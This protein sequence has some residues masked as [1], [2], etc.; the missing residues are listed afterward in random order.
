VCAKLLRYVPFLLA[1]ALNA[2]GGSTSGGG[3]L[4][5]EETP[6]SQVTETPDNTCSTCHGRDGSSAPPL[7]LRGQDDPA[8]RGVGAHDA[9]LWQ[10][11]LGADISCESCHLVPGAIDD[12]GHTDTTWP[13]EVIFSGLASSHEL[14]P[15]THVDDPS[16]QAASLTCTSVYCHGATL[17]GGVFTEPRWNPPDER[18]SQCNACHG[19]PPPAPHPAQP[20]CS[21]C[22]DAVAAPD[23]TIL[24][25][26][27]H[28]N[29]TVD[30]ALPEACDACHGSADTPAPPPD[31]TG[32]TNPDHPGV[33][34][35]LAHLFAEHKLSKPVE[36]TECHVVPASVN[37]PGHL[38]D[39]SPG[40]ELTFGALA[41]TGTAEPSYDPSAGK[42][43]SVYCHGA[44]LAGGAVTAPVWTDTSVQSAACGAC[45]AV[46]PP[47]PHVHNLECGLCHSATAEGMA[48]AHPENHINGVVDLDANQACN[49]CHGSDVNAAP[50]LDTTGGSTTVLTSVGAHQPHLLASSGLT[51]PVACDACHVVP[52]AMNVNGHIDAPPAEV[53]FGGLAVANGA[54]PAWNHVDATCS[55]VYCHGATLAGGART[56]PLWTKVDGTQDTCGSCHGV[57]P[58]APHAQS[59]DCGMCHTQ[60]AKG[61]S[62]AHPEKHIDGTLQVATDQSCHACHG[63]ELNDAPPVDS[64]GNSATALKTIGAHQSHLQALSNI[65]APIAC[66][67]CHVVPQTVNDATHVDAPPAEVT[68]GALATTGDLLPE[69]NAADGTCS[70]TYCHGATLLGG[71]HTSPLWTK[72][73]GTQDACGSCHGVPPP[74]PHVQNLHCGLCHFETASDMTIA[75]P[76]KHVDGVLQVAEQQ[77][78]HSCHGSTTNDAPPVDTVGA[79]DTA[80]VSIGAHQEHLQATS[81]LSLPVECEQCHVRPTEVHQPGHIDFAPAE[82]TFGALASADGSSPQWN[83]V[84]ATC[85]SVYCHGATLEGGVRTEPVWTQVDHTQDACGSCHGLPPPL[86]HVQRNDCGMCHSE[87]ASGMAIVH[88]EKH[89]DGQVQVDL[90]Q[91]CNA[92]HGSEV[93]AAPP[94]DLAGASA[95]TLRTVGAHQPHLQ[96]TS[97]LS[98]PVACTECHVV[99]AAVTDAGHLGAAPA[100]IT[101]GTLAKAH[102]ANP[103][104]SAPDATCSSV[105]CHGAT[106]TGGSDTVP[107]WTRVDN[108]EDA[109]GACHGIPPPAPHVQNLNCGLCHKATAVGSAIVHPEKHINGTLDVE[110]ALSCHSCHGSDA[111]DAPPLDTTGGTSTNLT[112]VGAHQAHVKAL[113]GLSTP[114]DCTACHVKPAAVGDAGHIDAPPAE[115]TFNELAK[116]AG[117]TPT[118]DRASAT[119]S[120]TYCHG[121]TLSGGTIT[122]PAWTTVD[123]TEDACGTCHGAPPPLPHLQSDDCGACH[124]ETAAGNT[125]A[126]PEKHI[127]GVLQVIGSE[128][129]N[130]CHGNADNPAPP[131]DT[132]GGSD[133]T[134]VTVGAHQAH[135]QAEDGIAP[136]VAC[137]E[138]HVKP[139]VVSD[140][141]H[142][143]GAPAEVTFGDTASAGGATPTWNRDDATC[144]STY[145]HGATLTG[146]TATS[147]VWTQVDDTQDTCG[148]CHGAPPPAPHVQSTE[149]GLCHPDTA[150]TLTITHPEK[151]LDGIIEV[152]SISTCSSCHGS[153]LNPAPPVDTAGGSATSLITVGAHQ[154]HVQGTS[155]LT[156]PLDCTACHVKPATV[157]DP[158]H[159]DPR[160]AEV[161]F[162]ALARTGGASPVW[163]AA[164]GVC[165]SVYCHGATLAGGTVD[166]PV[167]T[168]VDNTADACGACHGVPPPLPHAQRANC[169][170]C[171]STTAKGMA[172]V[173]LDK[174][175][176]G[177]LDVDAQQ[178]CNTCHG[179]TDNFA[180]PRDV[181][182]GEATT[183][184]TVGAHQSHVKAASG[185]AAPIACTQCHVLPVAVADAGHIDPAPAEVTFGTVAKAHGSSPTWNADVATCSSVYCHGATLTGGTTVTP[186][187]TKVDGTQ[188]TCGSC[189]GV[190]PPAPHVQSTACG[191]CHA[192]TAEGMLI[193]NP[194][195]HVDGV[196]DVASS[197]ACTACHGSATSIAPPVDTNGGA[198]TVLTTVGA[199]QAHLQGTS[200]LSS[201]VACDQ[202]H[203]VPGTAEDAGHID[204]SPAEVVFGK[205]AG[206]DGASPAW[207]HS[208]ATCS[209][210][211]CHGATLADGTVTAPVWTK[212]DDTQD[213]CGACHGVPPSA[214]H[215]QSTN[216]G[217]CHSATA[218]GQ[219]IAHPEKHIDGVVDVDA[220]QACN[221]CHGSAQSDAPPVDTTGGSSTTL[222][223][224]GAHQAHL[225]AEGALSSP[226]GCDEC[227]VVPATTLSAGHIDAAPAEVAF[228]TLAKAK[229]TTP[230]WNRAANTCS[231][232]YCHGATLQGGI[233]TTPIWTKV[234]HTQD[235]CGSCHGVPPP[236]PHVADADC[237]KC[238]AETAEGAAIAHPAK[239]IDGIVEVAM[240]TSCDACHGSATN[241]APPID[242]TG[243]SSTI[244]VTVGAH[245][246]HLAASSAL[247]APVACAE[248]HVVPATANA[249]G[250]IDLSPAEVTFGTLAGTGAATPAWNRDA[251]TCSSVYCHGATLAGGARTTPTWTKVDNTQ[252][253]CGSCHGLPPPAPHVQSSNCGLCHSATATGGAI[254]TPAKHINGVLDVDANQACNACHGNATNDAPPVDTT[255]GNATTLTT[256]G[257]HQAHLLASS[258]LSAPVACAECHVRPTATTDAG[259]IDAA[260]AELTFGSLAKAGGATPAWNRTAGTCSATYCH[261]ATLGAGGAVTT[262]VW[263]KVDGTQDTCTS[264]HGNPPPAPHVTNSNCGLCHSATATGGAITTPA[265]HINGTVDVDAAQACN[266][267]HG[268]ADNAAPPID[269]TGGSATT[270]TTV[271]AHQPHVKA[272]S[273]LASPLD[274]NACHV[275]P[276]AT[277]DAGHIDPAPAEVVFGTL[278]RVDGAIPSWTRGNATCSSTYCHGATLNAGG[279]ATA[280]VW[281]QV[282]GTLDTCASCHG[283]PPPAPH[284]AMVNC[285]LCHAATAT[286]GAITHPDKHVDGTVQVSMPTSCSAC[287]GSAANDA[288]PTDVSGLSATNLKTVGAHQAHLL[289]SSGLSAAV[290]CTECHVV[291]ATVDAVG[292]VD[293]SPAEVVFGTLAKT[294]GATP[295]W[296]AGAATCSS[297]Y[298]HGATLGAGGTATTPVWTKVDNTQDT[299]TSCHGNPPPA[300]H[301]T[302]TAC[303]TCHSE[304]M[305]ANGTI[306]APAKHIDGTVQ[307]VSMACNACHGGAVN[308]APPVDTTSGSATTLV[309]VGAHQPHLL[310][311]SSL[312]SPVACA[313]CHVVPADAGAAGH[314]DASPAE[315]VFG[316]LSKTGGLTPV[317]NRTAGTCSSTYCHGASLA[318]GGTTTA[319]LWTKVDNTQDTCTACHGN[320]PP[321]PHVTMSNCGLCHAATATGGA[322][323]HPDQHI[324]GTLDVSL[325]TACNACHGSAANDAPPV[326][327]DGATLTTLVSVGAHQPHLLASSAMSSPVA[328]TECHTVP[329]T[330][331]AAG[332]L[333][334]SPAELAFGALSKTGGLTPTWNGTTGVCSNTYCHGASLAAGGTTTAP[335]WTKVDGTQD[336]CGS[337]HGN[338]PPAPHS[339]ITQCGVCHNVTMN[340]NGTFKDATK[341]V[342]GTLD[343]PTA[344]NGCHGN[345]AGTASNPP[346]QAPPVDLSDNAATTSRG[347][348]AHNA[349]LTGSSNLS[350][351]I[352]C[353]QCH[354]V[355]NGT[356]VTGHVDSAMPAELTFGTLARTG[357]LTPVW[358]TS[359]FTCT[360]T[361][362]HG[363]TLTIAGGSNKVPTW[364]TVNNTQDAC[365]TCHA[366]ATASM[367]RPHP[368]G[369]T[370]STCATCHGTVASSNTAISNKALHVNGTVEVAPAS[371]TLACNGVCHGSTTGTSPA[372]QAPP[373]DTQNQTAVTLKSVGDHQNHLTAAA[374]ISAA[375]ACNNC[376][377]VPTAV[378]GSPH[379]NKTVDVVFNIAG[380][381]S[382]KVATT[383]YNA[384]TPTAATCTASYCHGGWTNSGKNTAYNAEVWNTGTALT[385]CTNRCHGLPPN[386]G[387][388]TNGNHV[389]RL[390]GV[391]HS[392]V[393]NSSGSN[394]ILNTTAARALHINGSPEVGLS[395]GGT[396]NATSR[397][398]SPSGCHGS[399]SWGARVLP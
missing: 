395:G 166:A 301:S 146:G 281:T 98:T 303:A 362:C 375:M 293:A 78:C 36:C 96:G 263:T 151:H 329:A 235:A 260:P 71:D 1:V 226:V 47:A 68:F 248:C 167:W 4:V 371:G 314:L 173:N 357:N 330:V 120:S 99:P 332:H 337:C 396:W 174:H 139:A 56:T 49:T 137:T 374:N 144:S 204:P 327:L 88:R 323:A 134:L 29:G 338:P 177:V 52:T 150:G 65:S 138:C 155:G 386:T 356:E 319:P 85:S 72:V 37:S 280:P 207:S 267:C 249:A 75:H 51:V 286:G 360:S 296:N 290:A 355:P 383:T 140:P 320:P 298:C 178:A 318:A 32:S 297:T 124:D 43:S 70:S 200:K 22:H 304:T 161:T 237:G 335:V 27:L 228:G 194:E 394:G 69:W 114:L 81:G 373:L 288:P 60:T 158:G 324:D 372:N 256:V 276:A 251:A 44:T 24:D 311:S 222:T 213:A 336:T 322:I 7:D 125:I 153:Q 279:S 19:N 316:A 163:T 397:S 379:L 238:H 160:P 259:H 212:V 378:A 309:T 189:H 127:D 223:S 170:L 181:E 272:T 348:G 48:I 123:G 89:I 331:T 230:A 214:P 315:V 216:C 366:N 31:L 2:C 147:P 87:T 111:D 220:L 359:A 233:R 3:T 113:S 67:E 224:V 73:D 53:S 203:A 344:C 201:P 97:G 328:C 369:A 231:S 240:P 282:D 345:A 285:G 380:T 333:D 229:N 217:M 197:Q 365:G 66:D 265:K 80:L 225:T 361:Y 250:H 236:A 202:C 77:T 363:T 367:S 389:N 264:C 354:L 393:A 180:P 28:I 211:Y 9:H 12:P 119:C 100:E 109:C 61:M 62:I 90:D 370:G 209:A 241:A 116:T 11:T 244:L 58:P 268:S 299:C 364:T 34:M 218:D 122:A 156:R 13:A 326:D 20:Q 33:G 199:H 398:C 5:D 186:T 289:A 105:Y 14:R 271:G 232:V 227:H 196:L 352:A 399:L 107:L 103:D 40:A 347:V 83:H 143:D 305:N 234:D 193:A 321:A 358:S 270:L 255:G 306:K 253:A 310:A 221:T 132:Q 275:K 42:C 377:P 79:Y 142:L 6:D 126:H 108:T 192:A 287:H 30:V 82:L 187:W 54:T 23:G 317:W 308:A 188:A 343:V 313:E 300:P 340:V 46:P 135:L 262:P 208:D 63:S 205:L 210:V 102:G 206:A 74:A 195:H 274:C 39:G 182:G 277:T 382:A 175:I 145:C 50:P 183:L 136:P 176:N 169:G 258:N 152:S 390:C 266:A 76:A 269:T 284:V 15:A 245:Q 104:W 141:A 171:H 106:L 350:S 10:N 172:I 184:R 273:G 351:A 368:V 45:H 312:A 325:P 257:A 185:I 35:H 215:V 130:A 115:L 381:L 16:D 385:G 247:S 179:N 254:S 129:C 18:A 392:T 110:A 159:I 162:S 384:T 128:D 339:P 59:V 191:A 101:F 168:V 346:D 57:P 38:D 261:G 133:T 149:C 84:S 219:T 121:A 165:S 342:N 26:K 21:I 41:E 239:H 25:R 391:C 95:T 334:P 118:W 291:P 154:P 64:T 294:G 93:N 148:S 86:P 112:T 376:H 91:A 55:A 131:V 353:N 190:P 117:A 388:H 164:S 8:G 278:A 246:P 307:V 198:A 17:A 302:S 283:N 252:D 387:R 243:G 94:A 157:N 341:H 349:H 242:I 295:A 292:H 92:C